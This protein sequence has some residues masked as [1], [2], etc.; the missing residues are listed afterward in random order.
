VFFVVGISSSIVILINQRAIRY[1]FYNRIQCKDDITCIQQP[2]DVTVP[3]TLI[4]KKSGNENYEFQTDV[5]AFTVDLINRIYLYNYPN[6]NPVIGAELKTMLHTSMDKLVASIIWESD[7]IEPGK[8]II[9]IAIR[10]TDNIYEWI[11]NFKISQVSHEEC[12]GVYTNIPTFMNYYKEVKVHKG[13][14]KLYDQLYP[15]IMKFLDQYTDKSKIQICVCGH[16]LGAAISILVGAELAYVD[17]DVVVYNFGSPRTGNDKLN[18]AIADIDYPLY[19]VNNTEDIT[20]QTPTSVSPN[21]N[22]Y[23]EPYFYEQSGT[24]IKYKLNWKSLSN[25]HSIANYYQGLRLL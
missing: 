4:T 17:Y 19:V 22:I 21:M 8:I 11:N 18:I 15:Q 25:N 2:L 9:W 20:T 5:A 13:F 12:R 6:I 10:G 23:N 24:E 16:S 3:K 14:M 7:S 1:T